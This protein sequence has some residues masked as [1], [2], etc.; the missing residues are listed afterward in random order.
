MQEL[1][2][3]EKGIEDILINSVPEM[4]TFE[5]LAALSPTSKLKID[6]EDIVDDPEVKIFIIWTWKLLHLFK[7]TIKQGL[8]FD[9]FKLNLHKEP[10]S[11]LD[12]FR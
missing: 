7:A 4:D 2:E 1:F 12:I 10:I 11:K 8:S 3:E 5:D 9:N 6:N